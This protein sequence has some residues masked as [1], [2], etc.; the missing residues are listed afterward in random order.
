MQAILRNGPISRADIAK[1]T[2]LSKQT[3][4]EVV[5]ALE[6]SGWVKECG[7]TV[8]KVGRSALTYEI[9]GGA[10]FVA[11]VDLGGTKIN[12]A[13]ADLL[14][15]IIAEEQ[16]PTDLRGGPELIRQI[17]GMVRGL[18]E[19]AGIPANAVRLIVLGTPGVVDAETGKVAIAP[20][21]PGFDAINVRDLLA[22]ATGAE[23]VVENDV[24]LAAKG[25]QWRGSGA[26]ISDFTFLALGTGIGMGIVAGGRLLR[27]ARG[28]AGEIAYLPVGGDPYDSRG[29]SLGTLEYAVGSAAMT[30][31][32]AGYGGA[33]DATARDVFAAFE[34]REPA[35]VATIEETARLLA[36]AIAAIGAILDPEVVILGGSIGIREE[37]IAEVR[38]ALA[39]C[40]PYP[41]RIEASGLG[42][43]AAM[44][45]CVGA[46]IE[47]THRDLFG[48]A[49]AALNPA[50]TSEA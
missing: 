12:A 36:P 42:S 6:E 46:A 1:M 19:R 44:I 27:G 49:A 7:R 39:R 14:G 4:S 22:R 11:G 17:A 8:G 28:G 25:E 34:Q 41:P 24:N 16:Q 15:E 47:K 33:A 38:R 18:A 35:A 23:V 50:L 2:G 40:T 20:N 29:F 10:R 31:R 48:V 5:R 26:G 30:R 43:R 37:L 32:Y 9:H 21:V 45:G 3:A 13:L